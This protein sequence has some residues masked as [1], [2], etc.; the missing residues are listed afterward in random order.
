MHSLSAMRSLFGS[1]LRLRLNAWNRARCADT[2]I[3]GCLLILGPLALGRNAQQSAGAEGS[4]SLLS[5]LKTLF[6]L[7]NGLW[8]KIMFYCH[9]ARFLASV[10]L[11]DSA[12]WGYAAPLASYLSK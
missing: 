7:N 9:A 3:L 8:I 6:S 5:G 2:L 11:S 12:Y 4:G 1:Q 10:S